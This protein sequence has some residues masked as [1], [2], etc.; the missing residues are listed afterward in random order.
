MD[1]IKLI[2]YMNIEDLPNHLDYSSGIRGIWGRNLKTLFCLQRSIECNQCDFINCT[3]LHLFEKHNNTGA[4]YRPYIIYQEKNSKFI[5]INFSFFGEIAHYYEK[6]MLPIL[7]LNKKHYFFKGERKEINIS[8]IK[9]FKNNLIYKDNEIINNPE[10][11]TFKINNDFEKDLLLKFESPFRMKYNNKLMSYFN[12]EAFIKNLYRRVSFMLE[13]YDNSE[14]KLFEFNDNLL[15]CNCSAD[16]RWYEKNR[17]SL[18]QNQKMS[19][20]GLIGDIIFKDINPDLYTL[21][22]YGELFHVGKQ[23]CFGNG[24]YKILPVNYL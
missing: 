3:Y 14:N 9:D 21:L 16:L 19:I 11:V 23:S 8:H 20:G 10:I 17:K 12:K 6:L 13:K 2:V 7:Q 15:N 4:D 24:K 1:F 5:Q 22:R 18:R